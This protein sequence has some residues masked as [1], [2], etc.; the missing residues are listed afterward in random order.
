MHVADSAERGAL[1]LPHTMCQRSR[2]PVDCQSSLLWSLELCRI[3]F[4]S[5]LNS[6]TLP[7]VISGVRIASH[8]LKGLREGDRDRTH[9]LLTHVW[10]KDRRKL[11]LRHACLIDITMPCPF[12]DMRNTIGI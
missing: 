3:L 12:P 9:F 1:R 5:I 8:S 6:G 10:K 11:H 7:I 4:E 2:L